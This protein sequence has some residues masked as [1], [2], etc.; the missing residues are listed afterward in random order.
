MRAP[1]LAG[2][3]GENKLPVLLSLIWIVALVGYAVGYFSLYEIEGAASPPPTMNLLFFAFALAGPLAMIWGGTLI[4]SRAGGL[5]AKLR[6]QSDAARELAAELTDLKTAIDQQRGAIESSLAT[7][8]LTLEKQ[9][10]ASVTEM[11]G[12]VALLTDDASQVLTKRNAALEQSL[13][14]IEN[15][16]STMI[17]QR[18]QGVDEVLSSTSDRIDRHLVDQLAMLNKMLDARVS[19]LDETI[20]DGQK[21]IGMVMEKRALGT[22]G[23]LSAATERMEKML[24]ETTERLGQ[25]L[26]KRASK[27]DAALTEGTEQLG[28]HMVTNA[29]KVDQRLEESIARFEKSLAENRSH[30]E[31]AFA[32]RGENLEQQN[33]LLETDIPGQLGMLHKSLGAMQASLAANPPVSDEALAGRLGKLAAEMVAPERKAVSELLDRVQGVEQQARDMLAQIDRTARLNA[34]LD[35][36]PL[37]EE[38]TPAIALPGLP[39][40]ELPEAG[41]TG[42]LDWPSL[43]STLDLPEAR[44][45]TARALQ[46]A[47]LN[48]RGISETLALAGEVQESLAEEGLFLQDLAPIHASAASWRSYADGKRTKKLTHE[49]AGI[50]DDVALTLAQTRLRS[51]P[52]FRDLALRFV[53]S[54][55]RLIARGAGEEGAGA[56]LLELAETKSGRAFLLL[57]QLTG[58]FEKA[59]DPAED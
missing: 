19:A 33:K 9:V 35:R 54:Y 24:A 12:T 53:A 56:R 2:W 25:E 27:V 44:S 29:E 52:A 32:R 7:S 43:L 46:S 58:A 50:K 13:A 8:L 4:A 14:R 42:P 39:F 51:E 3:L 26:D 15:T 36:L 23:Y 41:A 59:A 18:F 34:A 11:A 37:P 55:Q 40:A 30:V 17:S 22:D 21:R 20:S 49:M 57:G 1:G 6:E 10:E 45:D 5:S 47:A 28:R 48:D 16:M 38:Q 31:A